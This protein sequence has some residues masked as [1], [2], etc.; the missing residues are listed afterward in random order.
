MFRAIQRRAAGVNK[1]GETEQ[2]GKDRSVRGIRRG[3]FTDIGFNG[4]RGGTGTANNWAGN[5]NDAR[6]GA[7]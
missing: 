4:C 5:W 2:D 7:E 3:S 6:A 1:Q